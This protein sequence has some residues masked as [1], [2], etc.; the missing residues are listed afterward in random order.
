MEVRVIDFDCAFPD[1]ILSKSTVRGTP[2]Y[3]PQVKDWRDGSTKWDVWALA[4][5]I[6]EADMPLGEYAGMIS[7][8]TALKKI[9]AHLK[10]K[11]TCNNI[12]YQME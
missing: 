4:A 10:R 5:I 7:E 8:E 1:T 11:S 9:R 2:G 12:S 3:F 6:C